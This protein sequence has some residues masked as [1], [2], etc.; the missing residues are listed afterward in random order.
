MWVPAVSQTSFVCSVNVVAQFLFALTFALS[1]N[2]FE[3]VIFEIIGMRLLS[4]GIHPSQPALAP[5]TSSSSSS[6]RFQ[7][8]SRTRSA[9]SSGA[10]TSGS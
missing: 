2:M 7:A 3:L 5:R 1:V 8:R 9:S 6:S 4:G 10:W